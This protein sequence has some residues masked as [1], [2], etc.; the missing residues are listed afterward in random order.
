M[1]VKSQDQFAIEMYKLKYHQLSDHQKEMVDYE[2]Q[3][4][5]LTLKTI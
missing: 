3:I 2:F 1:D 5:L 4:Q